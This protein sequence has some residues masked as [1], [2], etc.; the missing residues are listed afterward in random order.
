MRRAFGTAGRAAALALALAAPLAAADDGPTDARAVLPQV[1][2]VGHYDNS[3]GSTDAASA[4][5]I[6]SRLI[7]DMPLLRPGNLLEYVP[8]MVVT[9]H[10]GSG[11][12]NQYFL[13]GFNLDH[14]TDFSTWVAGMPVNLRTHAHGQG[15]TDLNF[16]I[17]ELITTV[18][19]WKGPYY[20]NVGDFGSAGGASMHVADRLKQ[21]IALGTLG[22][23][24]YARALLAGT[25]DAGPGAFTYGL[26]Y[27]HNDGPWDVPEDFH[28]ANGVL[29][30]VLPVGASTVSVTGMA[31]SGR[32]TSTDQIPLRAVE[33]GLVGRYGSLNDTDGGS[34]QRYSLSLDA[35][36]PLAG[37]TYQTTAYWFRYKLDLFSDFTYFLDDPVNGDQFEQYDHR[38]VYGWTGS[39]TRDE[40]WGAVPVSNTLGFEMRQDRIDPVGLYATVDRNRLSTT[41]EDDVNEGSVGVYAQNDARLAPWMRSILGLRYDWYRFDV[42]SSTPENSGVRTAGIASPKMSLVFGP[43]DDTEYFVN[44]GYGFHSNDARGVTIKVDPSSGDPVDAATPLVRSK[45]AELGLRTAAI[46]NVQSSLALWYLRIASELVFVG[47]AG[48]TEAGRPSQRYGVEWNTR[49]RPLPWLYADLDVAW[50]HARFEDDA[51]EG[52]Y[53]PGAPSAVIAAGVAVDGYGPWSA[54]LFM[55][56]I[57]PYPL[58]EDDSVRSSSSTMFDAQVGYEIARNTRLRLDVFNLF[59]AKTNDIAYY[60]TSRLPGEPGAGV[61]DVHFHPAEKRS[62]RVT[63]AYRF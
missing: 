25:A 33:E 36:G 39:W 51:P 45:G 5:V 17:P 54:G 35:R 58:V 3:I 53:I 28:K 59:D 18:D 6:T 20:A 21:N 9:Q 62:F 29:R 13:R 27:M 10:S 12:A 7:D 4:G 23:F 44:A 19:Y 34:S 26:E 41:R 42:D 37:G 14:G 40:R 11:K 48:T 2:V 49:W 31:Y 43:W 24:G 52:S 46:R 61:D 47:D 30:Y 15:Y 60:Y 63:L 1:D 55:R 57:G 50:T 38:N 8:G 32:W 56:Y 16:L 22:D